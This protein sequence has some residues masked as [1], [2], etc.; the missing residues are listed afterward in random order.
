[1]PITLEQLKLVDVPGEHDISAFDCGHAEL[2]EFLKNECG[3]HKSQRLSH[4]KLAILDGQIVG[5][6]SLL[7]DSIALETSERQWLIQ[8]NIMFQHIPALKIGRL[9]IEHQF[10]GQDI[11]TALVK[12]AVGVAFRMNEDLS[13]GCRFLTVDSEQS[14][15]GFYE[16]MGFIRSLHKDYRKRIY[17]SM[18]YDIIQ[19]QQIG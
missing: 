15:V 18:H 16:K 12:Y 6:L 9:G 5:Y 7:A 11:G 17:P 19:G 4:S 14:S 3:P 8:K 13:V 10:K 2:N 1:V